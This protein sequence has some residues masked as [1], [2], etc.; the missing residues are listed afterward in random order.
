MLKS[1]PRLRNQPEANRAIAAMMKSKAAINAERA[2][3]V[4]AYQ[5][6]EITAADAR[7]ALKELN[8]RSI[9]TP[10]LKAALDG[11]KTGEPEGAGGWE[12]VPGMP[13]VK[14]K[15]VP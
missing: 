7:R 10:E 5:N 8:D 15:R 11:V 1:L 4:T 13:G 2:A 6:E 12:E 9:M 3:V 14:V